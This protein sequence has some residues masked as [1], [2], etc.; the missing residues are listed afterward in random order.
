MYL[1]A[2]DSPRRCCSACCYDY[3]F[4]FCSTD[5]P[6]FQVNH[7]SLV[8]LW[9]PMSFQKV[10]WCLWKTESC[11]KKQLQTFNF[12]ILQQYCLYIDPTIKLYLF[13]NVPISQFTNISIYLHI[14]LSPYYFIISLVLQ[15][16][17]N[18]FSDW[19]VYFIS[20]FYPWSIINYSCLLFSYL[21]YFY[22]GIIKKDLCTT[23]P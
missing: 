17:I 9:L 22:Q 18:V 23:M 5:I 8:T 3:P 7:E 19:G 2:S 12:N 21:V 10:S 6:V 16:L 15:E 13:N 14:Y 20:L 4:Q 1:L 11:E